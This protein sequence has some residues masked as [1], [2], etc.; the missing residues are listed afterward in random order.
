MDRRDLQAG[1]AVLGIGM[2]VYCMLH[3]VPRPIAR[4]FGRANGSRMNTRASAAVQGAT[5]CLTSMYMV[6]ALQLRVDLTTDQSMTCC[7]AACL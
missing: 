2:A 7:L 6:K 4:A 3:G 5:V 1:A